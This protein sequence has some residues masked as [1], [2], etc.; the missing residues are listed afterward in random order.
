MNEILAQLLAEIRE[1]RSEMAENRVLLE[2]NTVSLEEHMRRTGASENRIKILE[3]HIIAC[4]ARTELAASTVL[5]NRV[6]NWGVV[7]ALLATILTQ[8]LPWFLK[9]A[10]GT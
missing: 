4:P 5:W 2:R 1:I 7:A 10:R 8:L 9:W 3:D 6:R